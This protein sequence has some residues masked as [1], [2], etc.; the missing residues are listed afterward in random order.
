MFPITVFVGEFSST[1][2]VD[3]ISVGS[4]SGAFTTFIVILTDL[5]TS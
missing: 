3:G 4:S 2:N 1:L 5:L